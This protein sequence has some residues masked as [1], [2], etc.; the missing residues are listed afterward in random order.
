MKYL[1]ILLALLTF[2]SAGAQEDSLKKYTGKYIFP[3]GS[4]VTEITISLE[5]GVLM[6]NSALGNSELKKTDVDLFEIVSFGGTALF[7]RSADTKITGLNVVV[8]DVNIEGTRSE[9]TILLHK[10]FLH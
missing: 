2:N 3:E 6:A 5:N 1:I 9:S 4:P 8:G 7:R 10:I